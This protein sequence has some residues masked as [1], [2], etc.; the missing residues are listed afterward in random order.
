M[1]QMACQTCNQQPATVFVTD[2]TLSPDAPPGAFGTPSLQRL[3]ANCAAKAQL[4][5]S[6]LPGQNK[7]VLFQLL[8]KTAKR[9]LESKEVACQ[10]CGMTLHEFRAQGRMGCQDCYSV[11][12]QHLAPLLLRMHQAAQH[13]GRTPGLSLEELQRRQTLD[14]LREALETAVRTEAYEEAARLRDELA[15]LEAAIPQ[16]AGLPDDG[17]A[18][19][20]PSSSPGQ[21]E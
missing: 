21:P 6:P 14:G 10:R 8:Q 16:G 13:V 7:G 17:G 2:L 4:L 9:S 11:F 12:S 20:G 19:P 15:T 18:A 3:C 1:P 5:Q